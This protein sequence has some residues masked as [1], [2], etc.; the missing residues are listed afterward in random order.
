M[1]VCDT[2]K[3]SCMQIYVFQ[4]DKIIIKFFAQINIWLVFANFNLTNMVT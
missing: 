3:F 4:Y 2:F 1:R